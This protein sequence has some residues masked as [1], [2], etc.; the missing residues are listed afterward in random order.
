MALLSKNLEIKN[1]AESREAKTND[2]KGAE[3][4]NTAAGDINQFRE[5]LGGFSEG[6]DAG[7]ETVSESAS[8]NAS[9]NKSSGGSASGSS[10]TKNDDKIAKIE[11][12]LKKSR[13]S[14]SKM[15][16]EITKILKKEESKLT[17]EAHQLQKQKAY[18]S[19]NEVVS[20][21][22]EIYRTLEELAY[23]TYDAIKSVWLKVVHNI[24]N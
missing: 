10:S 19:L 12:E 5:D 14:E 1:K 24:N 21:I 13:P 4:L 16:K 6:I 22:R 23:A 3:A 9:E 15:I 20:K 18:S 2:S 7:K 11:L 8:E 17:K